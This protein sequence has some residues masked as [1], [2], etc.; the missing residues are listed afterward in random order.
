MAAK[1]TQFFW[2]N[3][4]G[5]PAII[6]DKKIFDGNFIWVDSGDSA[7]NNNIGSNVAPCSTLAGAHALATANNGDVIVLR[8]GHAE[9]LTAAIALTKA[10]ILYLGHGDGDRRPTFTSITNAV[11]AF[12][13]TG[14]DCVFVN[15]KFVCNIASQTEAID[16]AAD[17][18]EI[19]DCEFRE[20]SATGLAFITADTADGDSDNLH[21]H[22]CRFTAPTAG[23]Y[24]EAIQIGKDM[25]GVRIEDNYIYGDFDEACIQ[26]PAG[27]NACTE[28]E[29]HRNNLS[30]LLTGQHVIQ[31]S[32]TAVTGMGTYN[33]C[34]TDTQATTIDGSAMSW[35]YNTWSD[36]DGSNDEE[37][38]P[39]NSAI[40]GGVD[41]QITTIGGIDDATTDSL[42]G[43]LGTDA[44]MSDTSIFDMLTAQSIK[45]GQSLVITKTIT[46]SDI[47]DDGGGG[48]LD[49][50]LTGAASGS[51]VLEEIIMQTDGTGL[52]NPTTIQ[53]VCDNAKGL[54]G[55]TVP[56]WDEATANLGANATINNALADV[57]NLPIVLESTKKLYI[58]GDDGAGTGGGT[59]DVTMIFR[60]I[61]AGATIAA[62]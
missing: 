18:V 60:R 42:H 2:R 25:R 40:A 44:E 13:L 7:A 45:S 26:V 61:T 14:A 56:L 29:I 36:V 28:M 16:I 31:I 43:K 62:A 5:R 4:A 27:G 21:I 22:R 11:A 20:G 9:S 53:V 6:V 54:T 33:T 10:G 35:H 57:N 50:P 49:E 39:V 52:V 46:S 55:A 58:N 47:P 17:D 51:L 48:P 23:N 15:L 38:I 37:A 41:D 30:N 24:N 34:Q 19:F 8:Q 1:E 32:G 59:V 3:E 12:T